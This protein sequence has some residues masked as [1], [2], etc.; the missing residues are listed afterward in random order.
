MLEEPAEKKPVVFDAATDAFRRKLLQYKARCYLLSG[1]AAGAM[2]ELTA[3]DAVGG[4]A[5][6]TKI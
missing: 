6:V 3:I 5:K 2:R 1:N 4:G